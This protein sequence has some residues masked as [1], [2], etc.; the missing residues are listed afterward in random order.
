MQLRMQNAEALTAEQ[1][2]EFLRG[3]ATIDFQGQNRADLYSWVQGV[4]EAQEYATQGKKQRGR[5]GHA[6]SR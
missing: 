4:V 1:I 6:S 5:C 3:S 2:G